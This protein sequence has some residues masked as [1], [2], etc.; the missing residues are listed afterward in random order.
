MSEDVSA[1]SAAAR[2][3]RPA[4]SSLTSLRLDGLV[5]DLHGAPTVGDALD[6]HGN[7]PTI[8]A[9]NDPAGGAVVVSDLARDIRWP[10]LDAAMAGDH[11]VGSVLSMRL[12]APG[13]LA[14]RVLRLVAR[15]EARAVIGQ[16]QGILMAQHRLNAEQALERLAVLSRKLRMTLQDLASA[17]TLAGCEPETPRWLRDG[18]VTPG[19]TKIPSRHGRGGRSG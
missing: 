2:G 16:A 10:G 9:L 1:T 18:S 15:M 19:A 7:G 3:E 17:V 13:E 14:S 4:A 6:R 11:A 12:L 5:A 8:D